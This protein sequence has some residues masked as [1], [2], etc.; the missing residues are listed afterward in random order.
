MRTNLWLSVTP[1]ILGIGI[2]VILE[3]Q[4]T[5]MRVYKMQGTVRTGGT[6][7]LAIGLPSL[8]IYLTLRWWQGRENASEMWF[9]PRWART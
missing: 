5:M 9:E 6:W 7:Y 3:R 4:D 2:A 8:E 1:N